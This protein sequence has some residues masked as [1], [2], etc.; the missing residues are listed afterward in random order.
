MSELKNAIVVTGGIGT[1]KSTVCSLL[2]LYGFKIIDAD[3]ITAELL[4]KYHDDI[5]NLFG[6]KF[7]KDGVFDKKALGKIVFCDEKERKKL[8]EFLHPKI[9]AI[10]IEEA[11]FCEEKGVPYILD[12]PLYFEN[13]NYDDIKEVAVVYAT[14][15]QQWERVSKRGYEFDKTKQK[16]IKNILEVQMDIEEKRKR[17]KYVIDNSKDLKHLQKEVEKFLD[18][19]RKKYAHL[20]I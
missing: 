15:E 6:K 4:V 1:G 2:N 9:R 11:S 5:E 20:K 8:E 18:Y 16:I 10:M 14:K 3:K 12:I 7:Y 19:I 13:K 17:A